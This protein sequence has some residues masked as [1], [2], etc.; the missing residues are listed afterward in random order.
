MKSI[1]RFF[2]GVAQK[3]PVMDETV[4]G[5]SISRIHFLRIFYLTLLVQRVQT[6]IDLT[7]YTSLSTDVNKP[8][9]SLAEVTAC[10]G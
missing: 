2:V 1:L 7:V 5:E 10:L 9:R 3:K 8:S 6:D 4:F